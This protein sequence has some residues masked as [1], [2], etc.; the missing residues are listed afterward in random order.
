MSVYLAA[1]SEEIERARRWRDR[2][3]SVGVPVCS[4]WIEKVDEAYGVANP[5]NVS[6]LERKVIATT[7]V[8]EVKACRHLW[9]LVPGPKARTAG[10]WC[11]LIAAHMF[12]KP[13]ISSGGTEQSVFCALGLEYAHDDEAFAAI[14]EGY[15]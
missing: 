12:G 10:A 6:R 9:L 4:T 2:L 7:C 14:A 11:E 8:A 15:A 1:A 3:V 13:V 5:R